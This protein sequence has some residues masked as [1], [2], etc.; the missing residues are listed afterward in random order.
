MVTCNFDANVV[1]RE[2]QKRACSAGDGEE[3]GY[4]CGESEH[5]IG[6]GCCDNDTD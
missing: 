4:D 2:S 3:Y 1:G 5:V 6:G